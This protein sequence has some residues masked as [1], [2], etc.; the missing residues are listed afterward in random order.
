MTG[1]R[2]EELWLDY[3]NFNLVSRTISMPRW[4]KSDLQQAGLASFEF[5]HEYAHHLQA[6]SS[7]FGAA[8][9][10]GNV[11]RAAALAE[12]LQ[13]QP[14]M[15]RPL[16]QWDHSAE[17]DRHELKIET[18]Q[19]NSML[20]R[21]TGP[22]TLAASVSEIDEF[23]LTN[24]HYPLE[25]PGMHSDVVCV[26]RALQGRGFQVPVLAKTLC[27]GNAEA[28]AVTMTEWDSSL[29]GALGAETDEETLFYTSLYGVL[30]KRLGG[31]S[32]QEVAPYLAALTDFALLF[33]SM[34]KY[35][36]EGLQV[37][38]E[39]VAGQGPQAFRMKL[40]ELFPEE[41][42]ITRRIDELEPLR[43]ALEQDNLIAAAL[44]ECL[45]QVKAALELR[46]AEPLFF[47]RGEA[48]SGAQFRA[49]LLDSY[50]ATLVRIRDG[51]IGVGAFDDRHLERQEILDALAHLKQYI[52]GGR[53]SPECD[54]KHYCEFEKTIE[55]RMYPWRRG[56]VTV[57]GKT[58]VYGSIGAE[59]GIIGQDEAG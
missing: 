29:F 36:L 47:I 59:I 49:R 44:L 28:M 39:A 38:D 56:K 57:E 19:F 20:G 50:P 4:S 13:K 31:R 14:D 15:D 41:E 10:R 18:D 45:N 30:H 58:C 24:R 37:L 17:R 42:A 26:K 48:E 16:G 27:E 22:M 2:F 43:V 51:V 9:M 54:K 6:I 55:C 1:N 3:S 33:F 7:G 40:F 34:D 12:A 8:C 23:E 46:R 32:Q 11:G 35:F 25:H 52:L 5:L 53:E 21:L